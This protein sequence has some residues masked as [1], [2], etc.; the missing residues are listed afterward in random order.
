MGKSL[1]KE[2]RE[3]LGPK[4]Q[5]RA[6]STLT[7]YYDPP[8]RCFTFHDFQLALTLE[9]YERLIG[10]PYDTSPPYLFRGHYPSWASVAKV[11]KVS[12]SEILSQNGVEGIPKMAL[13]V[14][15]QQLQEDENWS[16]FIHLYR[17][18]VYDI[19]LF[20]QIEHYV[21]LATIDTFLGRRDQGEHL[22][23][24]VLA[25]TYY[26]LDHCSM[27][28][29]KG[30][31]CCTT[32]L[33]LWLTAHQEDEVP[34]RRPLLELCQAPDEGGMDCT[35]GRGYREINPMVPIME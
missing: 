4:V 22:V 35:L 30:L 20:L 31:R 3:S 21:D 29:G 14:R 34:Y 6:L 17:L 16:A 19:M 2:V 28:N 33:F 23:M 8:L 32:L 26:T 27:R 7:Q 10:M 1:R 13:E 18:L 24:V 15:L 11:L 5:P 25:D 9:E 12:E